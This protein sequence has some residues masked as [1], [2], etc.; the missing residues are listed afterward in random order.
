VINTGSLNK[1]KGK[2][3]GILALGGQE[4]WQIRRT[5]RSRNPGKS[6]PAKASHNSLKKI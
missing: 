4:G 2:N 3:L 6:M 1:K 5:F